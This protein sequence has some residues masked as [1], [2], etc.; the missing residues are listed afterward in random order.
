M[1]GAQT[2][3][4]LRASG[5]YILRFL[6]ESCHVVPCDSPSIGS[7]HD[8]I[9]GV[10]SRTVLL[11]FLD[12]FK[13]SSQSCQRLLRATTARIQRRGAHRTARTRSNLDWRRATGDSTSPTQPGG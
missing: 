9:R 13:P 10:R 1:A 8:E 4:E 6:R 11:P 12:I 3:A 7:A 2:A 5:A